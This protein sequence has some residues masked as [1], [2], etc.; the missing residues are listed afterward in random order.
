MGR[1]ARLF[2]Y[3]VLLLPLDLL[4]VVVFAIAGLIGFLGRGLKG[5][6]SGRRNNSAPQELFLRPEIPSGPRAATILI[7]N[8]DG[9]HLLEEC[10]PS[11]LE[12]VRYDDG[13]HEV[14]VVDNGSTDGSGGRW[15]RQWDRI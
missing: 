15:W 12:A 7:V 5:G 2:P 4:V 11:V 14:V 10:L 13:S 6:I 1:K 8:W 3:L 9:K